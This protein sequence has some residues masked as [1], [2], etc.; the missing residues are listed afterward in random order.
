MNEKKD[1]TKKKK[2]GSIRGV[3]KKVFGG[4]KKN[5]HATKTLNNTN[6]CKNNNASLTII[7]PSPNHSNSLSS[8]SSSSSLQQP[9][10][11]QNNTSK[12]DPDDQ[13][14]GKMAVFRKFLSSTKNKMKSTDNKIDA[15]DLGTL[16]EQID[17]EFESK[18]LEWQEELD[19]MS[20]FLVLKSTEEQRHEGVKN[21]V[22]TAYIDDKDGMPV[23]R[24]CFDVKHFKPEEVQ[25]NVEDGH[26]TLFAQ[27]LEEKQVA[28]YKK[29]MIRKM[30]LPK[31]VD[32]TCM[33][34]EL[35]QDQKVLTV[36]MPFHLPLQRKPR[37]P[38]VVPIISDEGEKKKIRLTFPVGL[39]FVEEDLTVSLDEN[40]KCLTVEASCEASQ[41]LNASQVTR[42][43]F[44]KKFQMPDFINVEKVE[45]SLS[46]GQLFVD[47]LLQHQ[48]NFKASVTTE[49][50]VISDGDIMKKEGGS[51]VEESD[52]D[53]EDESDNGE[54]DDEKNV[55]KIGESFD[56][57]DSDQ[58]IKSVN[59]MCEERVVELDEGK[60]KTCNKDSCE[61]TVDS[62]VLVTEM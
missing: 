15:D 35:S 14:T 44:R 49:E 38:S 22:D 8:S 37:G 17:E 12:D 34:C 58:I 51:E 39:D 48:P 1:E 33:H 55:H 25:L 4:S 32:H 36:E 10:N 31:H 43:Q 28:L 30:E 42:R 60:E 62:P 41:G 21:P 26:L 59:E 19:Q 45:H 9:H 16:A 18:K 47:V 46:G 50:V 5:D 6:P 20:D 23:L 3:L 11:T 53:V 2:I 52:G 24:A 57:K 27:C 7:S 13:N 40:K 54:I 61:E 56:E 29:T